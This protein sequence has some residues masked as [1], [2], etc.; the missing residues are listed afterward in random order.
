MTTLTQPQLKVLLGGLNPNRVQHLKG[1]AH[2]EAW[3]IR[4]EL[5]RVFGF[6]GYDLETLALD[7][8]AETGETKQKKNRQ[9][10]EYYGDPYT[11]WTVIYRAQVRLTIKDTEGRVLASWDDGAVGD[12]QNQ[13]VRGDAH[14]M[15]MKTALSQAL[16]RCATN[17][18]DQFG[19]S[20]YNDGDIRPVV[21]WSAAHPPEV[22]GTP[23]QQRPE[24]PPVRPEPTAHAAQQP[25]AMPAPQPE[26]EDGQEDP[27]LQKAYTEMLSAAQRANFED[28]LPAQ[29]Q[30]A[31]GHTIAEGTI[32]EY[33]QARDLMLGSEA[34]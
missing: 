21:G 23:E 5:I 13:P 22:D 17:L 8:V 2:M 18:G 24:D 6:G 28:Q 12:S 33:Q 10:G 19:L 15:A 20:L 25:V 7:L 4:R 30:R 14:D 1:L 32:A 3:D 26:P 9:T 34:A 27:D 11:A 31:F 16:K 29:F